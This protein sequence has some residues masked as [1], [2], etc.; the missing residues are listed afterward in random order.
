MAFMFETCY[1]MK[2][3]DHSKNPDLQ[4]QTYVQDSWGK[5]K[6]HFDPTQKQH[7]FEVVSE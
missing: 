3:T 1:L 2:L 6:K 4:D 7:S 5:L